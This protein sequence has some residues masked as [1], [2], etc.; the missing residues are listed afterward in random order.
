MQGNL[1]RVRALIEQRA[2]LAGAEVGAVAQCEQ[3][4]VALVES[5]ERAVQVEPVAAGASKS[6][7]AAT[8]AGS[9]DAGGLAARCES[10]ERRDT[11]QPRGWLAFPAVVACGGTGARARTRRR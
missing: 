4:T 2:D 11:D 1:N 3:L 9:A 5:V 8:S 10:T 7:G 6:P